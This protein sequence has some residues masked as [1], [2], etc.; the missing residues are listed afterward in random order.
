MAPERFSWEYLNNIREKD[1]ERFYSLYQGVPENPEGNAVHRKWFPFQGDFDIT[2]EIYGVI[3]AFDP[4]KSMGAEIYFDIGASAGGDETV[5]TLG[6]AMPDNSWSWL[7]QISGRWNPG[8]RDDEIVKFCKL[9]STQMRVMAML[10]E[11]IGNGK[12]TIERIIT[13]IR[14]AGVP[15]EAIRSVGSK[16]ERANDRQDSFRSSAQAGRIRLYT[17]EYLHRIGLTNARIRCWE[18]Y[19][20]EVTQL[21]VQKVGTSFK[22]VGKDNKWDSGTGLHNGLIKLSVPQLTF[23]Q[24]AAVARRF[25]R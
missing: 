9:I 8:E 4:Q 22:L 3:P 7:W 21:K 25:R 1:P 18:P 23:E 17:G 16:W 24:R 10:E 5:G 11:G 20:R 12:E 19:L 6:C 13:K 2:D 14:A 15:A